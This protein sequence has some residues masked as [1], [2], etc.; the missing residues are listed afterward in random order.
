[1]GQF[2]WTRPLILVALADP[3]EYNREHLS[4]HAHLTC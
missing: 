4:E 1:M 2:E 3:A